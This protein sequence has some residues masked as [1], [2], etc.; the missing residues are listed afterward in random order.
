MRP[1]EAA[2]QAQRTLAVPLCAARRAPRR[3]AR[4]LL[5]QPLDSRDLARAVAASHRR[6]PVVP[7][8]PL[9]MCALRSPPGARVCALWA[10][11]SHVPAVG[12]CAAERSASGAQ[13]PQRLRDQ[14]AHLRS[15]GTYVKMGG[16]ALRRPAHCSCL[17]MKA[18][19]TYLT[20]RVP[21]PLCVWTLPASSTAP[22]RMLYLPAGR[23]ILKDLLMSA[24]V[25]TLA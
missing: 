15:A 10:G 17:R 4:V 25:P 5:L 18:V 14:L 19:V 9:D 6:H 23:L 24:L 20:V 7:Q 13:P 11:S 2:G 8:S 16:G 12:L 21:P 22:M 3:C 1:R